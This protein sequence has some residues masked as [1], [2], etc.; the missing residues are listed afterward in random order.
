MNIHSWLSSVML[1]CKNAI[2][3]FW[4]VLWNKNNKQINFITAFFHIAPLQFMENKANFVPSICPHK[5]QQLRI[6]YLKHCREFVWKIQHEGACREIN[7]ARGEAECCIYLE[8]HPRVLYFS[9]K[10]AKAVL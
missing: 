5:V 1:V 8:T 9:Y 6:Y 10:R 7:T 2:I 4:N 3:T